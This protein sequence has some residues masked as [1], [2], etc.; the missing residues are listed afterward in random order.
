VKDFEKLLASSVSSRPR[1]AAGSA[2]VGRIDDF[3]GCCCK[4]AT[5]SI[6]LI[7]HIKMFYYHQHIASGVCSGNRDHRL[8]KPVQLERRLKCFHY[9][10][11]RFETVKTQVGI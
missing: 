10:L 3:S 5:E 6:N 11:E 9:K 7:Y 2:K 8:G 4:P 1:V